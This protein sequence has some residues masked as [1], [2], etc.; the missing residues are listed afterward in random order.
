MKIWYLP[1][2]LTKNDV[3]TAFITDGI[4]LIKALNQLLKYNGKVS[5]TS[6]GSALQLLTRQDTV[7]LTTST[8]T[9]TSMNVLCL[10]CQGNSGQIG[11]KR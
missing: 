2:K 6:R 4:H 3:Q 11:V 5:N 1:I 8:H 7:W 10:F 9:L